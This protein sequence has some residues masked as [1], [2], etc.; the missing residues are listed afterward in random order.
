M[1]RPELVLL[2]DQDID[3]SFLT[4]AAAFFTQ[5]T[6]ADR[7]QTHLRTHTPDLLEGDQQQ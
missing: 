5:Y 2:G 1:L 7:T 3:S 6:V 4:E